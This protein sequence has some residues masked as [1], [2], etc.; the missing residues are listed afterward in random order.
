MKPEKLFDIIG[1]AD[2]QFV[3]EA[4]RYP[5]KAQMGGWFLKIAAAACFATVLFTAAWFLRQGGN[6][7]SPVR[8][9]N[10]TTAETAGNAENVH[11]QTLEVAEFLG[12]FPSI[13]SFGILA[14][15]GS[16]TDIH[17][18]ILENR[19]LIVWNG[20]DFLN[21]DNNVVYENL[22]FEDMNTEPEAG[23]IARIATGFALYDLNGNDIPEIVITLT[24][25]A[26]GRLQP[27]ET[28]GERSWPLYVYVSG[29][30]VSRSAPVSD[31]VPNFFRDVYGNLFM[32][33][34]HEATNSAVFVH[35]EL[36][37]EILLTQ[38]HI[39]RPG[40]ALTSARLYEVE[41]SVINLMSQ[42]FGLARMREPA[43]QFARET[44]N[45]FRPSPFVESFVDGRTASIS[46]AD[47]ALAEE[48]THAIVSDFNDL[49]YIYRRGLQSNGRGQIF[50]YNGLFY[51]EVSDP[52][53]T[54]VQS[55]QDI[56]DLTMA[57]FTPES[58]AH[59][60]QTF[61]SAHPIYREFDGVL[62]RAADF[63]AAVF[64]AWAER[65]N[66]MIFPILINYG[67]TFVRAFTETE[68][69]IRAEAIVYQVMPNEDLRMSPRMSMF[70][71]SENALE[72]TFVLTD[73]GWRILNAWPGLDADFPDH[74]DA[75]GGFS[76]AANP[77]WRDHP[78]WR[79]A[80]EWTFERDLEVAAQYMQRF[81]HGSLTGA[82]GLDLEAMALYLDPVEVIWMTDSQRMAELGLT[83]E[84]F[85]RHYYL[86]HYE[87]PRTQR[88]LLTDETEFVFIDTAHLLRHQL[89]YSPDLVAQPPFQG[90]WQ[91]FATQNFDG[92]LIFAAD[93]PNRGSN[94]IRYDDFVFHLREWS[95]AAPELDPA[96]IGTDTLQRIVHFVRVNDAGEVLR[97]AQEFV[98]TQ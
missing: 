58:A 20:Y 6:Y 60:L 9:G 30:W 37:N 96:H 33:I 79:D 46:S 63:E 41:A 64:S 28:S 97:I 36:Y 11:S 21:P 77:A 98:F 32:Q 22:F 92:G 52:N 82:I 83:R 76:P 44:A 42:R 27:I 88:F 66:L 86:R 68:F 74:G 49:I 17:G 7:G 45:P 75:I 16:F 48:I 18:R 50:E 5:A 69:T 53:F 91:S 73:N 81:H 2:E 10:A 51:N 55:V 57:V 29:N 8:E 84:H 72:I 12:L 47:R 24:T 3:A 62:A 94:A 39:E 13:F 1:E 4:A 38:E 15:D 80:E 43:E 19:P 59:V 95:E 65:E 25:F 87:T 31:D 54:S 78:A 56:R 70:R 90:G 93:Q 23:S 14:E 61:Y 89:S 67:S 35:A 71:A 34:F 26:R 85:S 40:A